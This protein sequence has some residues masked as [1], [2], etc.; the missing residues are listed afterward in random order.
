[1]C[2]AHWL[3]ELKI[4]RNGEVSSRAAPSMNA[5]GWPWW[6]AC[7]VGVAV[8]VSEPVLISVTWWLEAPDAWST[9]NSANDA[10][11]KR[12]HTQ[13]QVTRSRCSIAMNIGRRRH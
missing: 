9:A 8:R 13:A 3:S 4:E 10:A 5:R 11:A 12:Q 2:D 1:M 6:A 7:T